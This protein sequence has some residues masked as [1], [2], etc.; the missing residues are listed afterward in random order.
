MLSFNRFLLQGDSRQ[1]L[2][3]FGKP[4][5]TRLRSSSCLSS[6]TAKKKMIGWKLSKSLASSKGRTA[7]NYRENAWSR[8]GRSKA[9]E[10]FAAAAK[11]FPKTSPYEGFFMSRAQ[12]LLS[13]DLIH[14]D[15]A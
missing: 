3:F 6:P 8:L 13:I 5:E 14:L 2:R 10:A 9:K 11:S 15:P 7:S 1:P 12:N 4:R